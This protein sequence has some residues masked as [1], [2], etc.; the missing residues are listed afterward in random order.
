MQNK[1]MALLRVCWR[2][3]CADYSIQTGYIANRKSAFET[4]ALSE[5]I[6]TVPQAVAAHDALQYAQAEL[7]I[8]NLGQVRSIL[9]NYLQQ[10]FNGEMSAQDA[11]AAAQAEA[12][13]ALVPFCE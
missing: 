8:Q 5:Y 6:D 12:E 9:H 1:Q 3:C 13:E 7:S 2:N 11:M 10:A 4:D